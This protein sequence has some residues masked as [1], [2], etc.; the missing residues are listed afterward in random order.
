MSG[1][2]RNS[3]RHILSCRGS[4]GCNFRC[5]LQWRTGRYFRCCLQWRTGRYQLRRTKDLFQPIYAQRPINWILENSADPDQTP[6]NAASDQSLYILFAKGREFL[7]E[8]SRAHTRHPLNC[9]WT[10]L[11]GKEGVK[12]LNSLDHHL[13]SATWVNPSKDD[14][15]KHLL[16][17]SLFAMLWNWTPQ[18]QSNFSIEMLS[19]T[20]SLIHWI[21]NWKRRI[22]SDQEHGYGTFFEL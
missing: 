15:D 7:F 16:K 11:I 13:P 3:R 4:F 19:A 2:V 12:G 18:E 5:C 14:P 21:F 17:L 10:Y 22:T 1:L 9:K 20:I 8:K 6:Q